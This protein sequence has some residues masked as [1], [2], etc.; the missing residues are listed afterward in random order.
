MRK[1]YHLILL[2]VGL[3][4]MLSC[5]KLVE[6]GSPAG[7]ITVDKVFVSNQTA[8]AVLSAIY[9]ELNSSFSTNMYP[10]ITTALSSDELVD[11]TTSYTAFQN[12]TIQSNDN[13][14]GS[15]WAG[16]YKVI[17]EINSLL[18]GLESSSTISAS[19]KSQL[20]G[21]AK[22]LRAF[23]Y[24]EL[25][26][27]YD[28]VPLITSTNV[29]VNAHAPRVDTSKIYQQIISDLEDAENILSDAYV[30]VDRCRVNKTA[31]IALLA[32]VYLYTRNWSEAETKSSLVINSASYNLTEDLTKVF[33]K[34]SNETIFQL[35]SANGFTTL[36][37]RLIASI[38]P[39]LVFTDDFVNEL[40]RGDTRQASW[41]DSIDYAGAMYFYPFKYKLNS[42]NQS[43]TAE[44]LVVLRL[45]EQYLIRAEARINN[46]KVSEGIED[47][48]V[49]RA[50][51]RAIPT[52]AIP[53]PLPALPTSLSLEASK[54]A[55]EHERRIELFSEWGHRWF[56]LKR[57][58]RINA[59]MSLVKPNNWKPTAAL[60]PIP[61]V[62]IN[63]NINLKQNT[64]YN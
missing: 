24:F 12:N 11:F 46:N 45:G 30:G 5:K 19:L 20:L 41:I 28:Q 60:Y 39:N 34:N 43:D 14:N 47:L 31:A 38:S 3:S 32:R 13:I 53:D 59:I 29:S 10:T 33:T 15:M 21:E 42:A 36:G 37:N 18:E 58:D 1:S 52:L 35:W 61:L 49:L 8:N 2:I 56:D 6:I 17:Y 57:T 55:V 25:V 54:L 63:A 62:E 22:F 48:N 16:Y 50:R 44:N 23:S 40:E 51:A 27:F 4:F 7:A 64:G 9:A 26:N